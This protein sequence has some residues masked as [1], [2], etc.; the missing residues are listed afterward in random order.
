MSKPACPVPVLLHGFLGFVRR[1]PIEY[2][3]GVERALREDGLSPVFPAVPPTTSVAE[4]AGELA[5]ILRTHATS[6]FVL[7][8]HSMGGLDGRYLIANLDPDHRVKALVTVATPHGGTPVA[9]RLLDEKGLLHAIGRRF[10]RPALTDLDPRTRQREV[11]PDRDDVAYSSYAS[12]RP[13]S[14]IPWL[15]TRIALGPMQC[16]NDGLVPVASAK[17]GHFRGLLRADHFETVGWSF[18]LPSHRAM[19]P[20]D[21]I[22]FWRRA[23]SE[24]IAFEKAGRVG[25]DAS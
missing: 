4:R 3:R 2:F 7:I 11:I 20:F 24:A 8:G 12:H 5:R 1:G 15:I 6:A 25:N 23:V 22:S 17:W 16:D 9:E 10:W 18:G 13:K 19:R 21:H 14:E